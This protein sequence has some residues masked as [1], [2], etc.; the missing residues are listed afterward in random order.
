M[1]S[2]SRSL[3]KKIPGVSPHSATKLPD[4]SLEPSPHRLQ[5][6]LGS[7]LRALQKCRKPAAFAPGEPQK[8]KRSISRGRCQ[9]GF[10]DWRSRNG[11]HPIPDRGNSLQDIRYEE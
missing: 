2:S 11:T 9:L 4:S 1:N 3:M 5:T 6:G 10:L 7:E 8:L